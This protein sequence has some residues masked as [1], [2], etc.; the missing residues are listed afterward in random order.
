MIDSAGL[1]SKLKGY[2]AAQEILP[3]SMNILVNPGDDAIG[4]MNNIMDF[5]GGERSILF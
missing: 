2:E 1:I 3:E 5:L 4:L